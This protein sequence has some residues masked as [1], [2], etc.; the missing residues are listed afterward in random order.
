MDIDTIL[1]IPQNRREW[2]KNTKEMKSY[3]FEK[4]SSIFENKIFINK[5]SVDTKFQNDDELIESIIE[6]TDYIKLI[7]ILIGG[8]SFEYI[9]KV[10]VES[11]NALFSKTED[12]DM[13]IFIPDNIT[14][15]YQVVDTEK[16]INGDF[17]SK[18]IS[19]I[20]NRCINNGFKELTDVDNLS[21]LQSGES[22][23]NVD[24]VNIVIDDITIYGNI[25]YQRLY[26]KIKVKEQYQ[27]IVD[28]MV[29]FEVN[30]D[31]YK[32]NTYD[33][34]CYDGKIR[35]MYVESY[36]H[37]L[38]SSFDT[39][40]N[41]ITVID[42]YDY[43]LLNHIGRIFYILN[44]IVD[45]SDLKT[46]QI[47]CTVCE[48]FIIRMCRILMIKD[49]NELGSIIITNYKGNDISIASLLSPISEYA[50]SKNINRFNKMYGRE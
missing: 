26:F 50:F 34:Q 17:Y 36:I 28:M 12:V 32:Y 11:I 49:F 5:V 14:T 27:H 45:Y 47:A 8:F 20:I 4:L 46:K 10:D 38:H 42:R 41:Y 7:P 25:C 3:F 9:N 6:Y 43:K 37:L 39:I 44:F 40:I 22:G 29:T 24:N 13:K 1:D 23:V 31:K 16:L 15:E 48:Q 19:I 21:E 35:I 2:T 18:I 30:L 33:I